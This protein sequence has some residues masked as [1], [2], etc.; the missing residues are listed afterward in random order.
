MSEKPR[1]AALKKRHPA[2]TK[3]REAPMEDEEEF[4]ESIE[5]GADEVERAAG[6]AEAEGA[7]ARIAE[8]EAEVASLKD[9]LLRALAEQENM[10]KRAQRNMEAVQKFA[11]AGFARDL[12][13]AADNLRRAIESASQTKETDEPTARLLE[14]IAAVERSLLGAFE[15]HGLRRIG[16]RGEPFDPNLHEAVHE[17]AGAGQPA[18]TILAVLQPGY[19]YHDRLLRPAMVNVSKASGAPAPVNKAESGAT[20]SQESAG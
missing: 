12:L 20:A 16:A 10:R 6:K 3:E 13:D 5:A 1:K 11:A 15:K 2:G 18:G 9:R 19:L 17:I 4:L 14:G 8:L 7:D